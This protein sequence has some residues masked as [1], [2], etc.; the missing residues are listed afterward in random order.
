MAKT[1]SQRTIAW[2]HRRRTGQATLQTAHAADEANAAVARRNR[3]YRAR[4]RAA[5]LASVTVRVPAAAAERVRTAVIDTLGPDAPGQAPYTV[6]PSL[7]IAAD[8]RVS[9]SFVAPRARH[10]EIRALAKR[11]AGV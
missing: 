10:R 11:L 1:P 6:H 7:R 3:E 4:L 5:G 2:R 9:L 8:G